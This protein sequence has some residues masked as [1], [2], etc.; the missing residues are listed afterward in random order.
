MNRRITLHSDKSLFEL[1]RFAL[2]AFLA[3]A[4]M[5]LVGLVTEQAATAQSR[6]PIE[7]IST[8]AYQVRDIE[9][10]S[11]RRSFSMGTPARL[12]N[13]LIAW[14]LTNPNSCYLYLWRIEPA[15]GQSTLL[16]EI[17]PIYD[18]SFV[19]F[20]PQ[21]G[22]LYFPARA[23][24]DWTFHLWSTDGTP[25]GTQ[26][27]RGPGGLAFD[28]PAALTSFGGYLYFFAGTSGNSSDTRL[29]R[30]DGTLDGTTQ[31]GDVR[32]LPPSCIGF[33]GGG[34]C[35]TSEPPLT[36]V[37]GRMLFVGLSPRYPKPP[38]ALFNSNGERT[39][40]LMEFDYGP[41]YVIEKLGEVGY[42]EVAESYQV[43]GSQLWRT[44]GRREGTWMVKDLC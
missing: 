20:V 27:V 10:G 29:W 44:D 36:V 2:K 37:D 13:Y 21:A 32:G 18:P 31:V 16:K 28:F 3:V 4:C 9:P 43:H 11:D 41:P 1:Y 39:D 7:R 34:G 12:G 8:S 40:L 15:T 42:F 25:D 17:S 26:Q 5:A 24:D 6:L 35:G 30:T 23:P 38:Y 14:S 19:P 33:E 22:R